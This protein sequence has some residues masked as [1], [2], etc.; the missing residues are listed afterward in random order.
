[1]LFKRYT[2]SKRVGPVGCLCVGRQKGRGGWND[3]IRSY[4]VRYKEF[5]DVIVVA[6]VR[7]ISS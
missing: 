3:Q 5:N 4:A 6:I 1:M 2:V 7:R